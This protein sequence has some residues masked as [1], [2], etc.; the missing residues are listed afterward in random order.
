[1]RH[2]MTEPTL[3]STSP[4]QVQGGNRV[5]SAAQRF[6]RH[7]GRRRA[8]SL[9]PSGWGFF[10]YLL[11]LI[12]LTVWVGPMIAENNREVA[13]AEAAHTAASTGN[14]A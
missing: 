13:G 1:M 9:H 3:P 4:L 5:F 10:I 11:L 14:R 8:A 6:F 7:K 2:A 12:V